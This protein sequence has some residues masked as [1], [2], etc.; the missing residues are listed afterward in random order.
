MFFIP[1]YFGKEELLV[2]VCWNIFFLLSAGILWN[3]CVADSFNKT[4]FEMFLYAR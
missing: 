1:V 2:N 3:L 4:F